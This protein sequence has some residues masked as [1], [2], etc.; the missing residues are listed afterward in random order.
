[1][2]QDR[3]RGAHDQVMISFYRYV[4]GAGVGGGES[5]RRLDVQT[6]ISIFLSL[7]PD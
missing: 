5:D 4:P 1:M 2:V 7:S 6:A 3:E